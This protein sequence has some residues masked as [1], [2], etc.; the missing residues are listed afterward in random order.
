MADR[1]TPDDT[2]RPATDPAASGAPADGVIRLA[3]EVAT[4][5][6]REVAGATVRVTTRVDSV[7]EIVRATT[8]TQG[9]DVTRVPVDRVLDAPAQVRTEGDVVIVPVMEEVAV[10]EMRL[11]LKEE[12]HIRRTST[13]EDVEIPVTVRKQRAEIERIDRDDPSD[14]TGPR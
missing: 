7:E 9:V 14:E 2:P 13:S 6:T 1:T 3:E 8:S 5:G 10:V 11:V 4:V 12:L